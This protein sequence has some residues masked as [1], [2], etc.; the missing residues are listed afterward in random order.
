MNNKKQGKQITKQSKSEQGFAFVVISAMAMVFAIT[1]Y[2]LVLENSSLSNLNKVKETKEKLQTLEEA[3]QAF[4]LEHR[5]LPCPAPLNVTQSNSLYGKDGR[6]EV[7]LKCSESSLDTD[8]VKSY[9]A[10]D[11]SPIYY[12][13]VPTK[14]LGLSNDEGIDAWGSKIVYVV[15]DNY[16]IA[17]DSDNDS[18]LLYYISEDLGSS[19]NG[20]IS[21]NSNDY[22]Y[23]LLSYGK[24]RTG[25]YSANGTMIS[26]VSSGSE[27][28][29]SSYNT[30]DNEIFKYESNDILLLGGENKLA[31]LSI[32]TLNSDDTNNDTNT[33]CVCPSFTKTI[34]ENSGDRTLT[35]KSVKCGEKV[36]SNE[37]CPYE[38]E[39]SSPSNDYY[40]SNAYGLKDD[41]TYGDNEDNEK[42]YL[43][44]KNGE[45][46]AEEDI[47]FDCTKLPNC[48]SP[49]STEDGHAIQW[50]TATPYVY[51]RT[52]TGTY[53]DDDEVQQTIH[54]VC[55]V[56]SFNEVTNATMAWTYY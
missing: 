31:N 33:D 28:Q 3:L 56:S 55:T 36:Y 41:G 48:D 42:P 38:V 12:G 9:T 10:T 14:T 32:V 45:T 24:D 43:N 30:L 51:T 18:G 25:A 19:E 54:G 20:G 34:S 49:K 39:N 21:V 2:S 6:T 53:K 44:C 1:T 50:I 35:F 13:A 17:T 27:N 11:E 52:I 37:T 15:D 8:G 7:T 16:T 23:L 26:K 47:R 46:W 4:V 29:L 5:Y 22:V 40:Y